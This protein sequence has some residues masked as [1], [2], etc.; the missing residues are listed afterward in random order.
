MPGAADGDEQSVEDEMWRSD[1]GSSGGGGV[2]T[3][4]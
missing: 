4:Y 2:Q 3:S 1:T